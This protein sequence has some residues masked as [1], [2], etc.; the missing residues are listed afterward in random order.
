MELLVNVRNQK[1]K[2]STNLKHLVAGTKQFIKIKFN[3]SNDWDGLNTYAQFIQ[4]N[5]SYNVYLDSEN[6]VFLPLEIKEGKC[7]IVLYG[8]NGTIIAITD[9]LELTIK[10]NLI[11][12]SKEDKTSGQPKILSAGYNL[13]SLA[14]NVLERSDG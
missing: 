4:D 7:K 5:N 10:K 9:Y 13:T 2:L 11:N 1:L 14:L 6:S 3:L 12:D 8:T